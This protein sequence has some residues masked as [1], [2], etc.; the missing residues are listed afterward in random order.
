MSLYL[1]VVSLILT[2]G[3][4]GAALLIL[5]AFREKRIADSG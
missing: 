1:F 5:D 2:L 3:T 4:V